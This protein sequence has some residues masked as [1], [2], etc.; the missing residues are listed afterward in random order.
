MGAYN[1]PPVMLSGG[2]GGKPDRVSKNRGYSQYSAGSYSYPGAWG[3]HPMGGGFYGPA[4][5][6]HVPM[7]RGHMGMDVPPGMDYM[8]EQF[9]GELGSSLCGRGLHGL[10]HNGIGSKLTTFS[11]AAQLEHCK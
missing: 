10:V 6:M 4:F 2:A 11:K 1:A 3:E 8:A 7:M 9:Q 5:G